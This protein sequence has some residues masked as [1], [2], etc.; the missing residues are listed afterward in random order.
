MS[1]AVQTRPD[2]P[3]AVSV[4]LEVLERMLVTDGGS[5]LH[6]TEKGVESPH[7]HF[8]QAMDF[9][10]LPSL[11][12]RNAP[13]YALLNSARTALKTAT[14]TRLESEEI[15]RVREMIG[16][17]GAFAFDPVWEEGTKA[18]VVIEGAKMRGLVGEVEGLLRNLGRRARGEK[19]EE[20]VMKKVEAKASE[21]LMLE[22]GVKTDGENVLSFAE[23][24]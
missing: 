22:G 13:I 20:I 17:E 23:G 19:E 15:E 10:P 18:E 21:L 24:R 5:G 1:N 3:Q 14:T 8:Q 4:T 6:A 2:H 12:K 16:R 9:R 7:E 11:A